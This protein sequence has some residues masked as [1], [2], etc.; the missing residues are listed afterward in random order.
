MK[1]NKIF[2]MLAL[3]AMAAFMTA[4]SDDEPQRGESPAANSDGVYF[5]APA[6]EAVALENGQTS[7]NINVYREKTADALTISVAS[8][9][10]EA[11]A[12]FTFPTTVSFPAGADMATI[13]VLVDFASV[14]PNKKYSMQVSV[15]DADGT[16]YGLPVKN[17]VASYEPWTEWALMQGAGR[18]TFSAYLSGY[19]NIPV[20]VRQSLV[21]KNIYQYQAGNLGMAGVP[22]ADQRGVAPGYFDVNYVVEY[23]KATGLVTVPVVNT[24]AVYEDMNSDILCCDVYT[25]CKDVNPTF[26]GNATLAQLA[27]LNSF[28]EETGLF[29]IDMRYYLEVNQTLGFSDSFEYLQLP[30]YTQYGVE[31]ALNGHYIDETGAETQII[32]IAMTETIAEVKYGIYSGKLSEEEAEAKAQELAEDP[33]A[34]SIKGGGNIA[35]TLDPATYTFVAAGVDENGTYRTFDYVTFDYVSVKVDPN[36]GWT[37]KGIVYYTE[38]IMA[39]VFKYPEVV[40]YP[41][42]IQ[43]SDDTPGVYRLVNPYK[44]AWP[45][46][47]AYQDMSNGKDNYLIV[48]AADPDGVYIERSPMNYSMDGAA[49]EI[50]SYGYELMIQQG[51]TLAA[52]KANGYCGKFADGKITMPQNKKGP[53]LW[54]GDEGFYYANASGAFCIDFNGG[55]GEEEESIAI[56]TKSKSTPKAYSRTLQGKKVAK[57]KTIGGRVITSDEWIKSRKARPGQR[58]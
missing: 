30:G 31:V 49:L 25:Y 2:S 10:S 51:A 44:E 56:R 52:L 12:P 11:D 17:I 16:P 7:F 35:L 4:C 19:S 47:D 42:E 24:G 21:D 43:E 20:Y 23:N 3:G 54:V 58:L 36:A 14:E 9:K 41:V 48:N 8:S 50:S 28:N 29:T 5:A 33:D 26:A 55:G 40:T 34:A 32:S 1:L 15:G 53:I 46:W 57:A 18:W 37:S 27:S 6:T 45:Y 38:D 13:N 22:A 39:S